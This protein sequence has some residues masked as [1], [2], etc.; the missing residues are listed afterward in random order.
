MQRNAAREEAQKQAAEKADLLNR[1]NNAVAQRNAAREEA[2]MLEAKLK[3]L[4][5]RGGGAQRSMRRTLCAFSLRLQLRPCVCAC[6][7]RHAVRAA[8]AYGGWRWYATSSSSSLGRHGH[9]S[10]CSDTHRRR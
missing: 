4:Q 10:A 7:G 1:L 2:L 8:G 5:V 3:Q 9:A 6:A